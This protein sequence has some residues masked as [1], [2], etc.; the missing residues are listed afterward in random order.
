MLTKHA[1]CKI[2]ETVIWLAFKYDM[3]TSLDLLKNVISVQ[4]DEASGSIADSQSKWMLV[5]ETD[6]LFV[7]IIFY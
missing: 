1:W 2:C 4:I 3:N 6:N 5:N 7:Y